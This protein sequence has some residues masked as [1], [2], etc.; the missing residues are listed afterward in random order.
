MTTEYDDGG[1][2]NESS[3]ITE[4]RDKLRKAEKTA[5]G[6]AEAATRA[7]TAERELA[8]LKAGVDPSK[9]GSTWFIKGYD[10]DLSPDAIKKAAGEAG[11]LAATQPE[12]Q[13]AAAQQQA[14]Q[15]FGAIDQATAGNFGGVSPVNHLENMQRALQRGGLEAMADYMRTV[16]LPV[17][18]DDQ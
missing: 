16:G 10:G 2:P 17:V 13:Q 8:F 6:N 12:P 5:Q 4:L 9:A 7:E 18:G 15:T 14:A 11:L 3:V 1:T